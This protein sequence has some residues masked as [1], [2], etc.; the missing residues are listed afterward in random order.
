VTFAPSASKPTGPLMD[1]PNWPLALS[2]QA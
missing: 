2:P 1:R